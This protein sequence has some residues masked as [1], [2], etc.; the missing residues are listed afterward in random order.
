MSGFTAS[1]ATVLDALRG[2][3][4]AELHRRGYRRVVTYDTRH[5][6]WTARRHYRYG[7]FSAAEPD[8]FDVVVGMHPDGA[9]D[10]AI[11]YAIERRCPFAIVPCCVQPSAYPFAG[12]RD[13]TV[14]LAH[15]VD[16][17]TRGGLAVER[18]TLGIRGRNMVLVGRPT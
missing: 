4:N 11:A 9:T 5:D 16:L 15:L 17:A 1:R 3:L 18:A 12:P 14:W 2:Y 13:Y 7:L 8:E 6:R 10:E